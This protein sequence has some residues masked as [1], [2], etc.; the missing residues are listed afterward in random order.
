MAF[1]ATAPRGSVADLC[2]DPGELHEAVHSVDAASEPHIT[3]VRMNFPVAINATGFKPG[4]FNHPAQLLIGLMLSTDRLPNPGVVTAGLDFQHA[5]LPADRPL[6]LMFPDKGV[7]QSD[8]FAKY[9]AA[10]FKI[11]RSS[12]ARLSSFC[13]RRISA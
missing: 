7:P 11:S 4:L 12:V 2:L 9:A 13:R 8:S 3:Q 1:P 6:F 10:F 5:T